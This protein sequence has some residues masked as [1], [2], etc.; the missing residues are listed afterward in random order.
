M[1]ANQII[2]MIIRQV[3]RR[4]V[5]KGV[6]AGIDMASRRGKAR[7]QMTEDERARADSQTRQGKDMVKRARKARRLTRKLF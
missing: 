1:N 6:D 4:L 5:N 2:N 3:T 7:D